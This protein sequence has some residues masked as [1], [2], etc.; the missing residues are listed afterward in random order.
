[1]SYLRF[2]SSNYRKESQEEEAISIGTSGSCCVATLSAT[3]NL[4][5]PHH[6]LVKK[7]AS[8]SRAI[9]QSKLNGKVNWNPAASHVLVCSHYSVLST[10]VLNEADVFLTKKG[11]WE[12][13]IEKRMMDFDL[14][15][16]CIFLWGWRLQP[17]WLEGK[18]GLGSP[19]LLF[20]LSDFVKLEAPYS[21]ASYLGER[22]RRRGKGSMKG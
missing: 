13:V 10:K 6:H 4:W 8:S 1:M 9:Q 19:M 21:S 15:V 18:K 7:P 5:D 12:D 3:I 20:P 11:R 2:L 17:L 14:G 22:G 16:Y